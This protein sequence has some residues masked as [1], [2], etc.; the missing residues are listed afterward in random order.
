M[1]SVPASCTTGVSPGQQPHSMGC[2]LGWQQAPFEPQTPAQQSESTLHTTGVAGVMQQ[3]PA[4]Q[5]R[6]SQQLAWLP[7]AVPGFAQQRPFSHPWP[8]QQSVA[9]WQVEPD[10][11]HV[12]PS[13]APVPPLEPPL[14]PLEELPLLDEPVVP[15]P[16][17]E[18]TPPLPLPLDPAVVP[19]EPPSEPVPLEPF[20][21]PDELP[22]EP[23][24]LVP[25]AALEEPPTAPVVPPPLDEPTVLPP[26]V[27]PPPELEDEPPL[28]PLPLLPPCC[29]PIVAVEPL[30]VPPV[31]TSPPVP[32]THRPARQTSSPKQAPLPPHR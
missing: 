30:L 23:E 27:V 9:D 22:T 25:L 19:D 3:E 8:A 26:A 1:G 10:G 29:P 11:P 12:P 6:Y 13:D 20:A 32:R 2:P 18:L 31:E 24:P 5:A 16:L 4:L 7:Q 28:V 17:D 14:P 15:P 21:A